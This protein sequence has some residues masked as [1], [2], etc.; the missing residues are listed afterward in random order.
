L[1]ERHAVIKVGET[2]VTKVLSKVFSQGSALS[3][4][5][6]NLSYDELL[7]IETLEDCTIKGFCDDTKIL[8]YSNDLKTIETKANKVLK[9]IFN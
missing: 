2:V 5:L 3:P 6:W 8:I 7:T 1:S 9:D 4:D